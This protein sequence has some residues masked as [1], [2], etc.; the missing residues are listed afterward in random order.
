MWV[1]GSNQSCIYC[2][3]EDEFYRTIL[4][5]SARLF[6]TKRLQPSAMTA[7]NPFWESNHYTFSC[8]WSIK[9]GYCPI[10]MV[11]YTI[12]LSEYHCSLPSSTF[13]NALF[14][15]IPLP[16]L[17][18]LLYTTFTIIS[19]FPPPPQ[20]FTISSTKHN[21]ILLKTSIMLWKH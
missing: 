9:H 12:H 1:K 8:K 5:V 7:P 21:F 17:I 16:Q 6:K 15:L 2:Y 4:I 20:C 18:C 13:Y 3:H 14:K 11:L 10:T 19:F